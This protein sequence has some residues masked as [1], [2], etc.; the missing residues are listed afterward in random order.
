MLYLEGLSLVLSDSRSSYL[1]NIL[2]IQDKLCGFKIEKVM[3]ETAQYLCWIEG[4]FSTALVFFFPFF[5]SLQ[6]TLLV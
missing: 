2:Q 4:D 5:K 6:L 3:G 1:L